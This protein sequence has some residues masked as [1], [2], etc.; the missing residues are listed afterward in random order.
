MGGDWLVR[1]TSNECGR[2]DGGAPL[3]LSVGVRRS[4]PLV[5]CCGDCRAWCCDEPLPLLL[6]LTVEPELDPTANP[7]NRLPELPRRDRSPD[8]AVPRGE[9]LALLAPELAVGVAAPFPLPRELFRE[10]L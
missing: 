9:W 2:G 4:D 5:E 8:G 3:A 7:E 6:P 1:A 10:C